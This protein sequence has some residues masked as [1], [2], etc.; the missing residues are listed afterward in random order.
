VTCLRV[1]GNRAIAGGIVD[2]S[3]EPQVPVGSAAL[4]QVTDGGTPGAGNDSAINLLQTAPEDFEQCR[5]FAIAEI[6]ITKGNIVVLAG[7]A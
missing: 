7:A 1:D 3:N 6:P 2:E 5:F 4:I